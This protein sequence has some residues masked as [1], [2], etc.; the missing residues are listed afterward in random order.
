M[1]VSTETLMICLRVAAL[2]SYILF[3][4]MLFSSLYLGNAKALGGRVLIEDERGEMEV[5]E[6]QKKLVEYREDKAQRMMDVDLETVPLTL[7]LVWGSYLTLGYAPQEVA[8]AYMT[9]VAF[10]TFAKIIHG[11]SYI[12]NWRWGR[13]LGHIFGILGMICLAANGVVASFFDN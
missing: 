8:I 5:S 12:V 10:V 7:I 1:A 4:K 11:I 3:A 6:E 2:C 9:F 13:F